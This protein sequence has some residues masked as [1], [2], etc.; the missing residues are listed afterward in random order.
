MEIF[1]DQIINKHKDQPCLVIGSGKSLYDLD[2]QNFS[3]KIIAV[4]TTILRLK[5]LE[6]ISYLVSA[7]NH[8]P[9]PEIKMHLEFLNKLNNTI[10]LMS[11]TAAYNDI[12]VK[13]QNF[14]KNN[15]KIDWLCFDDRHAD[16]QF[17]SPRSECCNLV[18][19]NNNLITLQEFFYKKINW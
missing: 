7:N 9:I 12:W 2:Y 18:G 16:G 3:G 15:L 13:N 1:L 19:K 8:F 10:W 4:G 6:K 17:C 14:L 11:D 5:K